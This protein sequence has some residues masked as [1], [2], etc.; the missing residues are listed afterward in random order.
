MRFPRRTEDLRGIQKRE[1]LAYYNYMAFLVVLGLSAGYLFFFTDSTVFYVFLLA[2]LGCV[3]SAVDY[4]Y[5]G[6][7]YYMF[8]YFKKDMR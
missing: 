4:R 8:K 6:S 7:K 3:V 1:R 2:L 5:W